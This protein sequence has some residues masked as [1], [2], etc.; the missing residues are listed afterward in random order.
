MAKRRSFP[1]K[2]DEW[3]SHFFK[4]SIARLT[5]SGKVKDVDLYDMLS[6][7]MGRAKDAMVRYLVV[8]LEHPGVFHERALR[9]LSMK[10]CGRS[11]DSRFSY[12]GRRAGIS[13]SKYNI[14]TLKTGDLNKIKYIASDAFRKSYFYKCAFAKREAI[15]RYHAKWVENLSK[16]KDIMIFTAKKDNKIAGFLILKLDKG[17]RYGRIILIAVDK[18]HRGHGVGSALMSKCI[19]WGNGQIRD[20]FVKTQQNNSAALLLYKKMGFKPISYDKI[21]FKKITSS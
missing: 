19:E 5:I 13:P 14:S 2:I 3:D 11:V 10:E 7:L 15:D 17:K 16:A 8:K 4:T 20:I 9:R 12:G 21:F 18:R 1:V 6:G